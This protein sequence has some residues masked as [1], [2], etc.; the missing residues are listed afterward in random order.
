MA[1]R[2]RLDTVL[3]HRRRQLD[4]RAREVAIVEKRVE[5]ARQAQAELK[6]RLCEFR[7]QV[8]SKFGTKLH[9][10][11]LMAKSAWLARMGQQL[12][13]G[14]M[15]IA[16]LESR[17]EG[18]RS[19]LVEAWRQCE[20]LE[21]LKDRHKAEYDRGVVRRSTMEMDETGSVRHAQRIPA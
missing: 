3:R 17:R 18:L 20:V 21:K 7:D 10:G 13:R 9:V 19:G 5:S 16:D 4:D 11:D 6:D 8:P 14:E 1:F 12:R 2:F 15:E